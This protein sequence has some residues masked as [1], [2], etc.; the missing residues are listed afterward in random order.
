MSSKVQA[1][2]CSG[3][4][5]EKACAIT[6]TVK[7][8]MKELIM[9]GEELKEAQRARNQAQ[10]ELG[11]VDPLSRT[12]LLQKSTLAEQH[13]RFQESKEQWGKSLLL[14]QQQ[15]ELLGQFMEQQCDDNLRSEWIKMQQTW[16]DYLL[17]MHLFHS[18]S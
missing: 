9:A 2:S 1:R 15:L 11:E 7:I 6:K 12:W 8:D 17:D 13:K 16:K 3:T 5:L 10:A 4:T 14:L 18:Y